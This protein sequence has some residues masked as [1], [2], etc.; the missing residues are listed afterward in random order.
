MNIYQYLLLSSSVFTTSICYMLFVAFLP[1]E[2]SR[3]GISEVTFGFIFAMHPASAMFASLVVGKFMSSLG[4]KLT[5]AIG[6]CTSGLCM[7]LFSLASYLESATMIVALCI[8]SRAASGL[9][10]SMVYT[11]SYAIISVCYGEQKQKY[12]SYFEAIQGIGSAVGP[13]VGGMLYAFFGFSTIFEI[14]GGILIFLSPVMYFSL[15]SSVENEEETLLQA[16]QPHSDHDPIQTSTPKVGYL[17]LIKSKVFTLSAI[18][19]ALNLFSFAHYLPVMSLELKKMS[20]SDF[21]ISLFFCVSSLGYLFSSLVVVPNFIAKLNQ[22]KCIAFAIMMFGF[23]QFL[24]GPVFPIPQS[25]V[26]MVIGQ[27]CV[28]FFSLIL[29]VSPVTVMIEDSEKKFPTQKSY[30]TDL[31]S[32]VF[33]FML[34]LGETIGPIFGS[35]MSSRLGFHTVCTMVAILLIVYSLAYT[36]MC[37]YFSSKTDILPIKSDNLSC[38]ELFASQNPKKPSS[39]SKISPKHTRNSFNPPKKSNS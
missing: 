4:R 19:V 16:D 7:L 8:F 29:M 28:G 37:I 33:I 6:C 20:V 14:L 24:V 2:F 30:V 36:L 1:L 3:F 22:K 12:F 34:N 21:G 10:V 23:T 11:T 17:L 35:Y 5:L 27:F 32:G 13:A 15:P 39:L 25:V 31:S 38:E 18:S 26:F 9:T